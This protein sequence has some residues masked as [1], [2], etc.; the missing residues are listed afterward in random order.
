MQIRSKSNMF[1]QVYSHVIQIELI[2]A[3]WAA[4][5][6]EEPIWGLIGLIYQLFNADH[7]QK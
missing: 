4:L 7:Y 6:H 2:F 3:L 1:S 5:S